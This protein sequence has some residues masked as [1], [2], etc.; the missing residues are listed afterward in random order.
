MGFSPYEYMYAFIY[1]KCHVYNITHTNSFMSG[2]FITSSIRQIMLVSNCVKILHSRPIKGQPS[3]IYPQFH[4]Y[5]WMYQRRK[6]DT[7]IIYI[8]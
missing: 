6:I 7:Y 4:F 5:E 1:S 8:L 2:L 3:K